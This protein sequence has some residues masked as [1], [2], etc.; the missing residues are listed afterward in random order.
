ME[1]TDL[2][3]EDWMEIFKA[4]ILSEEQLENLELLKS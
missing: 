4:A 2:S 3:K 1:K